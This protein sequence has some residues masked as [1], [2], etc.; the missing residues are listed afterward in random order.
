MT[1][2]QGSPDERKATVGH[3]TVSGLLMQEGSE[4]RCRQST[5]ATQSLLAQYTG[6]YAATLASDYKSESEGLGRDASP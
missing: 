3:V 4:R 5:L 2:S 6:T 1:A